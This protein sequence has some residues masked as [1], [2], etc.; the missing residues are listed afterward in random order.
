MIRSLCFIPSQE[1]RT[2]VLIQEYASILKNPKALLW[3]DFDNEPDASVGPILTKIFHFH[4]LAVD[5][6]LD[7]THVPKVDDWGEYVYLVLNAMV[8][9]ES[10]S[11]SLTTKELDVFLGKN[12]VV[13]HHDEPISSV[14]KARI[15]CLRDK[16]YTSNGPDHLRSEERR[17]GK[18]CRS[19]WSPYH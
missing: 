6:A 5:D 4:Q 16:R 18:E 9:N 13:T 19:R 1:I 2:D 17:V 7:E 8:F 11:L 15:A 12:Y 14:D 10:E 3:I